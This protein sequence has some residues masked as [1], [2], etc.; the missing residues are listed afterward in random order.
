MLTRRAFAGSMAARLAVGAQLPRVGVAEIPRGARIQDRAAMTAAV[1]TSA[2]LA[3]PDPAVA[4][5]VLASG[6]YAHSPGPPVFEIEP[7]SR[8]PKQPAVFVTAATGDAPSEAAARVAL[9]IRHPRL[10]V[11]GKYPFPVSTVDIAPT[12]LSLMEMEVPEGLHGRD[13]SALLTGGTGPRPESIY[14]EGALGRPEE[15][16]MMVRGLDKI[17]VKRNLDVLHLYNLG[18]DPAELEDLAQEIGYR[19]KVDEMRALIRTWM[20]RTG[21]GMDPSGLKRR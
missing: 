18:E 20:R 13:L 6:R 16:R 21:D 3:C 10:T 15:W 12:L 8:D 5:K 14:A 4:P 7:V 19:L 11:P 9:A 2:W 17:V 1:F